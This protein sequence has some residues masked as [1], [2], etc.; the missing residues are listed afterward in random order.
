MI[1]PE[2][3]RV[4]NESGIS[5]SESLASVEVDT[6]NFT[7]GVDG[8][9]S[10]SIENGSIAPRGNDILPIDVEVAQESRDFA[11]DESDAK[12]LGRDIKFADQTSGIAA[13]QIEADDRTHETLRTEKTLEGHVKNDLRKGFSELVASINKQAEIIKAIRARNELGNERAESE[14]SNGFDFQS[15]LASTYRDQQAENKRKRLE[16]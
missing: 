3:V 12:S 7:K 16:S 15:R 14:T 11:A 4:F 6:S 13:V 5:P 2:L 9:S 10:T 8:L 1:D